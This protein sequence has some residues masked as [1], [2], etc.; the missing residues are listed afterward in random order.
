LREIANGEIELVEVRICFTSL[1]QGTDVVGV[2]LYG[3]REISNGEIE[4]ILLHECERSVVEG[5]RALGIELDRIREISNGEIELAQP[6]LGWWTPWH[7]QDRAGALAIGLEWLAHADEA[8][9]TR[10]LGC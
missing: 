1:E 9:S 2:E 3:I 6:L 10:C 8:S 5:L 4:L 7:C